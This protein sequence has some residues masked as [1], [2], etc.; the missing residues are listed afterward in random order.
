ME[1]GLRIV[2]AEDEPT[3]AFAIQFGLERAG[4][5]VAVVHDGVEAW[6]LIAD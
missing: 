3:L 6:E 1:N 4:F 2:V 5:I